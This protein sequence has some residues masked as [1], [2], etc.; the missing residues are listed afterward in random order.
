MF[1]KTA[2]IESKKGNSKGNNK[3]VWEWSK[4]SLFWNDVILHQQHSQK[5]MW[6]FLLATLLW[7]GLYKVG[8]RAVPGMGSTG[9][10]AKKVFL[11]SFPWSLLNRLS[12]V[13]RCLQKLPLLN[14]NNIWGML[15]PGRILAYMIF[16]SLTISTG[17][18]SDWSVLSSH[19]FLKILISFPI[20]ANTFCSYQSQFLFVLW[21][22]CLNY[23]C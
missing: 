13:P 10:A 8:C 1:V 15:N 6:S 20:K 11:V 4:I 2:F 17:I 3:S 9:K 18:S 7:R 16:S 5:A 21:H 19:K 14:G 23:S 22:L 12:E